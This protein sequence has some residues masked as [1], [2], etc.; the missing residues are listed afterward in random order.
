MTLVIFD[1]DGTLVYSNKID[2]RCFAETYEQIYGLPFPTIDWT[3]YP[4]VTDDTIFKTVIRDH[5]GRSTTAEEMAVFKEAFT[6]R[7]EQQRLLTPEEFKIVPGAK[8]TIEQ[9][10]ELPNYAVG[11]A[12][13]GWKKPAIL[14]L[15]FVKIPTTP[16]LISGADGK[17]T[18]EQIIEEV[19][20]QAAA[21]PLDYKRIVYVGDAIWDVKTTRNMQIP[22]IGLRWKGDKEFLYQHGVQHVLTDFL[23]FE[24]VIDYIENA[25]PPTLVL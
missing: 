6:K 2:S 1:V 9:L 18:R 8:R 14:K 24:T 5:F 23:D 11:I 13:G 22:L 4:H 15:N 7:I 12:T 25:Q 20:Q 16:L 21:I 3:K 17:E 19:L 10:L